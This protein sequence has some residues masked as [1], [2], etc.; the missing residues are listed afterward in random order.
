MNMLNATLIAIRALQKGVMLSNVETWK[1]T[2]VALAVLTSF[3]SLLAGFAV[4]MGWLQTAIPPE[5]IME[6]SSALVTIVTLVLAYFGVAT[7][8]RI[9][10]GGGSGDGSDDEL[11][12]TPVQ[13]N[14]ENDSGVDEQSPAGP[15]NDRDL[16]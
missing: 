3:L 11:Y 10:F 15:F 8:E 4:S 2:S 7:T 12:N 16:G 13:T 5:V 6:V 1:R 14:A 9:G